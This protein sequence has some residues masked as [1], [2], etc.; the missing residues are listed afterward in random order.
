MNVWMTTDLGP[1][2]MAEDYR[3]QI[4]RNIN[5]TTNV[6]CVNQESRYR[7]PLSVVRGLII[8]AIGG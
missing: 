1:R 6:D 8:Y 4:G 2:T 5:C 3:R 7:G